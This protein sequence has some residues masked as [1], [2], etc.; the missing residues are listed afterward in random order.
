[1]SVP[2]VKSDFIQAKNLDQFMF[3]Y[4]LHLSIEVLSHRRSVSVLGSEN[5]KSFNTQAI[6]LVEA[7]RSKAGQDYLSQ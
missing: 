6:S 1:M 2:P 7:G 5:L 3:L 4:I